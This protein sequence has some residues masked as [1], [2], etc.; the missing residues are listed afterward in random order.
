MTDRCAENH[1]EV[2]S[3][4]VGGRHGPADLA[5]EPDGAR[6][7]PLAGGIEDG[8]EADADETR[9]HVTGGTGHGP[10][11]PGCSGARRHV[12]ARPCPAWKK[13]LMM[14]GAAPINNAARPAQRTVLRPVNDCW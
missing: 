1:C 3:T 7:H 13:K 9:H 14:A 4:V 6:R 8:G 5:E 11:H 12:S 10:G 2:R